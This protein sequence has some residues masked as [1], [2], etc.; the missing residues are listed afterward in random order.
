[1]TTELERLVSSRQTI[2]E[3]TANIRRNIRHMHAEIDVG[4]DRDGRFADYLNHMDT[5]AQEI[6]TAL[7]C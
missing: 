1:V 4:S 7:G 2:A 6:Q 3:L 5:L